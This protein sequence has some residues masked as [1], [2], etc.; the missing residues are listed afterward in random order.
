MTPSLI[1]PAG[2]KIVADF[3]MKHVETIYLKTYELDQN[4]ADHAVAFVCWDMIM[5]QWSNAFNL[6]QANI[7]TIKCLPLLGFPHLALPSWAWL[8]LN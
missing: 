7:I 2:S 4:W 3:V 8:K 5:N 6:L 1:P